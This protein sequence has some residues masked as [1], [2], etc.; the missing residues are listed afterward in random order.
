MKEPGATHCP[1]RLVWDRDRC[2]S[3]LLAADLPRCPALTCTDVQATDAGQL[4]LTKRSGSH[5]QQR[6][7]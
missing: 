4:P 3:N 2:G 7:R 5:R 1:I 6:S